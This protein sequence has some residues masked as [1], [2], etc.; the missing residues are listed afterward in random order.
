MLFD[1]YIM[2]MSFAFEALSNCQ[3][4]FNHLEGAI[5]SKT[6]YIPALL[7]GLNNDSLL[8]T[9]A[10]LLKMELFLQRYCS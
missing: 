6:G 7:D 9:Q 8:Q 3:N 5:S 4:C 2:S 10:I 1:K